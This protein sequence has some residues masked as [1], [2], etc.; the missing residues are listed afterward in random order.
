MEVDVSLKDVLVPAFSALIG[1]LGPVLVISI[2]ARNDRRRDIVKLATELALEERKEHKEVRHANG[3][4]PLFPLAVYVN[5]HVQAL[6]RFLKGPIS[7]DEYTKI[8]D[9]NRRLAD[10][11]DARGPGGNTDVKGTN[12]FFS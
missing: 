10:S 8:L 4:G 2:Q 1:A 9:E 3:G 11:V 12:G 7:A 6:N 5:L